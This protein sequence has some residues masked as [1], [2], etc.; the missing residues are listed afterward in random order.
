MTRRDRP[1]RSW[2]ALLT[3]PI[4]VLLFAN[5]FVFSR[6]EFWVAMSAGVLVLAGFAALIRGPD[7]YRERANAFDIAIGIGSFVAL[8]AVFW[9][10]DK[11]I[12]LVFPFTSGQI[13]S[14]YGLGQQLPL[15]VIAALLVFV[16][17][18]GEELYW[19]GLV[20]WAVTVRWGLGPGFLVGTLLYAGT[21]LVSGSLVIVVAALVGGAV[22]S[23]IYAIRQRLL[24]VM[25][26]HVLF[27]LF[28][29]VLAPLTPR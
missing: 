3:L 18:P 21:H 17:G 14:V 28:V 16:I 26:S 2:I 10:G 9:I 20:Q 6:Q 12:R 22:W 1:R 15:L 11:L 23:A 13:G 8:Y 7:L 24:P 27:D 29:F 4:A 19:R 5:S 25:V